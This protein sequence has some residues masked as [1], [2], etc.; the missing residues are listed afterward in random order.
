VVSDI[1]KIIRGFGLLN[2][3]DNGT[4]VV[5]SKHCALLTQQESVTTGG[6]E[7]ECTLL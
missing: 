7:F 4:T 1:L 3:E 5:S 6:L 2:T